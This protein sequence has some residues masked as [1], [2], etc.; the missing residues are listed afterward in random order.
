[1]IQYN[2]ERAINRILSIPIIQKIKSVGVENNGWGLGDMQCCD[3]TPSRQ[4]AILVI[5]GIIQTPGRIYLSIYQWV[6]AGWVIWLGDWFQD[7]LIYELLRYDAIEANYSIS[8]GV[9]H[10]NNRVGYISE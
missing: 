3:V 2:K 6:N 9:C 8:N 4:P 5:V 1:M 7:K 10:F